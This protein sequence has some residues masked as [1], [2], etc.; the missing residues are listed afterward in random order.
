MQNWVKMFFL[1]FML[2][3]LVFSN[4]LNNEFLN[5][6]YVL[7]NNPVMSQAKFISSQWDPYASIFPGYYR[8][9]AH[10][11]YAF[12]YGTFKYHYWQY[13]LL[14]IFIFPELQQIVFHL[15]I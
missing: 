7:L 6:D 4:N 3:L 10:M 15:S 2:G 5:N 1:L 14:N 12:C 9:L 11:V 13:H 8:P